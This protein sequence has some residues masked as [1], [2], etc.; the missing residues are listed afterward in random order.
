MGAGSLAPEVE[1]TYISGVGCTLPSQNKVTPPSGYRFDHWI[2][3][4]GSTDT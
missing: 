4:V 2:L 1:S 3:R